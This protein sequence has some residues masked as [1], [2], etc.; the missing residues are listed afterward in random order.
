MTQAY[1]DRLLKLR[2]DTI[3][4]TETA[5]AVEAAKTEAFQQY[6]DKSGVPEQYIIRRWDHPG[7]R[8]CAGLAL[9]DERH[10]GP[11]T[12]DAIHYATGRCVDVSA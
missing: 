12:D 11:G 4:R 2:A 1:S 3:A 9:R 8:N 10:G 5:H 6:V 7:G